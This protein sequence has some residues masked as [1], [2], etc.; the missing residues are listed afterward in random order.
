MT[1]TEMEHMDA[2]NMFFEDN[3]A[4]KEEIYKNMFQNNEFRL[5]SNTSVD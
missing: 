1:E 2:D 5:I 4:L 3:K